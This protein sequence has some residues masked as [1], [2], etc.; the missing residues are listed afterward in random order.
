MAIVLEIKAKP[1]SK[2]SKIVLNKSQIITVH[3]KSAPENNKANQ[4]LISLF[5]K[6]LKI[7]K[8]DINIISGHTSKTKKIKIEHLTHEEVVNRLGLNLQT[9]IFNL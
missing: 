8:V 9:N 5:S 6:Y 7:P 4:E 2:E 3:I 1:K